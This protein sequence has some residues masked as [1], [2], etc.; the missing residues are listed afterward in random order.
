M[1]AAICA[2]RHD[3][4]FLPGRC[5]GHASGV[6]T[7][8]GI[9][10]AGCE[11]ATA[12]GCITG[13]E[14]CRVC[15][16][17]CFWLHP[18]WERVAQFVFE[19][20]CEGATAHDRIPGRIPRLGCPGRHASQVGIPCK[21]PSQACAWQACTSADHEVQDRLARQAFGALQAGG[22]EHVYEARPQS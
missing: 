4:G 6:A 16:N 13:G 19:S 17:V 14:V 11:R 22:A 9:P 7:R 21:H 10:E 8:A 2:D 12:H 1:L 5:R 20:E 18:G 3:R 15:V